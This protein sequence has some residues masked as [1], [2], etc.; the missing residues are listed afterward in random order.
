MTSG[1]KTPVVPRRALRDGVYE[2]LLEKL[3][4]GSM[5]P[6]A[7]LGIDSLSRELGVS[8]TP[9]REALVQMEHTGLV[10]RV[11]LK[12]YRVAH[13]LPPRQLA[14]LFDA[15]GML[16]VAAAERAVAHTDDLLPELR[17]AHAQHVL[18][19][20]RVRKQR[21]DGGPPADYSDLR[22]Y[23]QAD[24]EFH[25]TIIRAA[26][27][28]FLVQMA[29]SLSAHVHRMRQTA[30]HGALDIDQAVAEHATI[31][32]AFESGDPEA[33]AKALRT[34]LAA[35]ARRAAEDA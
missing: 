5:P 28:R 12:G 34:H 30:D 9:V 11:A 6:G 26:D 15:R 33:P 31:L 3:L 13:P 14:E 2:A 24:W 16:E 17:A 19:A 32:A 10:T 25:L 8:Q 20:H 1:K 18:C 35:V 7:S 21:G 23:F 29:E 22:E 27:N 4:D